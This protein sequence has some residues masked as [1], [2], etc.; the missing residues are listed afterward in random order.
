M[1]FTDKKTFPTVQ[2]EKIISF[3]MLKIKLKR[4]YVFSILFFTQ[5]E[6]NEYNFIKFFFY[7][8]LLCDFN[9]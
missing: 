3:L 4:Y 9:Y 7:I 1:N 8:T 6:N 2:I 5:N